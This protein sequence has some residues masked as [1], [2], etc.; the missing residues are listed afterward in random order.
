MV[1][2]EDDWKKLQ[3]KTRSLEM[4]SLPI[5]SELKRWF[6]SCHDILNNLL[7][8]FQN[9]PDNEWWSHILSWNETNGS[10]NNDLYQYWHRFP[11]FYAEQPQTSINGAERSARVST[12]SAASVKSTDFQGSAVHTNFCKADITSAKAARDS[13]GN[14]ELLQSQA[15]MHIKPAVRATCCGW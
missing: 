7:L 14:W 1:G 5:M 12:S 13:A 15:S 3:D 4:I 10:G 8:T 11:L 2:T 9:R 6:Q